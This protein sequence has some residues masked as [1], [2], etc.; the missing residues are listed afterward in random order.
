[1]SYHHTD[2]ESLEKSLQAIKTDYFKKKLMNDTKHSSQYDQER[3]MF[4][5]Q[6]VQQRQLYSILNNYYELISRACDDWGYTIE[7]IRSLF[8][9][10]ELFSEDDLKKFEDIK[11][12]I[13]TITTNDRNIKEMAINQEYANRSQRNAIKRGDIR[14]KKNWKQI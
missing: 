8:N 12:H 11:Q 9:Y 3:Y 13:L 2:F 10:P 4:K 1:M 5:Q 7:E 14:T 6:K